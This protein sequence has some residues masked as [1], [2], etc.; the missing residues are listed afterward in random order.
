MLRSRQVDPSQAGAS[1]HHLCTNTPIY[2]AQR[3]EGE[4]WWV[5]GTGARVEGACRGSQSSIHRAPD[6]AA[7]L[8][9]HRH[10]LP[11]QHLRLCL[12]LLPPGLSQAAQ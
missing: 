11:E 1:V 3:A 10:L 8:P 5:V 9:L 12:L 4:W 7:A 6:A 2:W